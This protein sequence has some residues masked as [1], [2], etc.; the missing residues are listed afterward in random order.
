MPMVRFLA[1]GGAAAAAWPLPVVTSMPGEARR[2]SPSGSRLSCFCSG[3][4]SAISSAF[5]SIAS[6]TAGTSSSSSSSSF[7][8]LVGGSSAAAPLTSA[9]SFT[10]PDGAAASSGL[11]FVWASAAAAG[12]SSTAAAAALAGCS[13]TS[14]A[15]SARGDN[16]AFFLGGVS[17]AA[18]LAGA[19][20]D[21]SSLMGSCSTGAG[22]GA[23]SLGT[24][25]AAGGLAA[26]EAG[27]TPSGNTSSGS[28]FCLRWR[29]K[30]SMPSFMLCQLFTWW[31]NSLTGRF[32]ST[33]LVAGP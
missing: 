6:S 30:R 12:G 33:E 18:P 8:T 1:G 19:P 31:R 3:F 10:S 4:S 17:A 20:G 11:F 9:S 13:S 7:A 24:T 27:R 2:S 15:D 14:G 29:M 28:C 22:L 26:L 23:S 16:F 5:S 32:R 21:P 25:G